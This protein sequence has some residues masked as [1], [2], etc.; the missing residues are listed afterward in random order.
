MAVNK[1]RPHK[2]QIERISLGN[3][4]FIYRHLNESTSTLIKATLCVYASNESSQAT[5]KGIEFRLEEEISI[6]DVCIYFSRCA[7][8]VRTLCSLST[9]STISASPHANL[10]DG[11][12][13]QEEIKKY[14]PTKGT[15][16]RVKRKF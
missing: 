7:R 5:P 12:L 4:V 10:A 13:A 9:A 2:K 1:L 11:K 3:N 8:G 15:T 14:S 16:R 6:Y